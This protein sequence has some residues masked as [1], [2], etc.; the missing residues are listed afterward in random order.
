MLFSGYICNERY[1]KNV[2]LHKE[3]TNQSLNQKS[4]CFYI[5][6][7]FLSRTKSGSCTVC[8]DFDAKAGLLV[9]ATLTHTAYQHFHLLGYISSRKLDGWNS[10][11][12]KTYRSTAHVAD[13]VNVVVVVLSTGAVVFA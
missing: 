3:A 7:F 10:D 6:A 8:T 4:R 5:G 2:N 12:F 11:A 13:K 9:I 1:L